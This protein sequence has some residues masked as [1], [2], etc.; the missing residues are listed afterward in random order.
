MKKLIKEINILLKES[1]FENEVRYDIEEDYLNKFGEE[2]LAQ[3]DIE[4]LHKYLLQL[5]DT[6]DKDSEK[7]KWL[8]D[9]DNRDNFIDGFT[10]NHEFI[11]EF[12]S[13]IEYDFDD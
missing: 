10:E 8:S 11:D 12:G 5:L 2:T 4:D 7:Y 13:P 9:E 1:D 6:Y 3:A